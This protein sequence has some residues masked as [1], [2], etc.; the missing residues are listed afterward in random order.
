M[1]LE[2]HTNGMVPLVLSLASTCMHTMIVYSYHNGTMVRTRVPMVPYGTRV[3]TMVV[4]HYVMALYR[5]ASMYVLINV[6]QLMFYVMGL[7]VCHTR[8]ARGT[9]V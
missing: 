1:V 8:I 7:M 5:H 9:R 4:W 3:R 6:L 2:Y